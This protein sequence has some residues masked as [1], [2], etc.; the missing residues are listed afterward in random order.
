[1][2]RSKYWAAL[3]ALAL[4]LSG[5]ACGD[6]E[7]VMGPVLPI[8]QWVKVDTFACPEDADTSEQCSDLVSGDTVTAG[9]V[10]IQELVFTNA[11]YLF[12]ILSWPLDG[13][14]SCSERNSEGQCVLFGVW[15]TFDFEFGLQRIAFRL[16]D[17]I[18]YQLEYFL[19]VGGDVIA[20]TV[21]EFRAQGIATA[22][23]R[24]SELLAF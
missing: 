18:D 5:L 1:M 21:F 20:D 10:Y 19:M 6:K 16:A 12:G 9:R 14:S 11:E 22:E 23:N 4:L 13:A 8:A 15:G 7:P 2:N 3:A 24:V 17:P